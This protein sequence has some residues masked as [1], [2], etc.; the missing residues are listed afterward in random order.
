MAPFSAEQYL[1]SVPLNDSVSMFIHLCGTPVQFMDMNKC[2]IYQHRLH[3]CHCCYCMHITIADSLCTASGCRHVLGLRSI[4]IQRTPQSAHAHMSVYLDPC[5]N[6]YNLYIWCAV[7]KNSRAGARPASIFEIYFVYV[8]YEK[9][10]WCAL[11]V[12]GNYNGIVHL[13]LNCY[14]GYITRTNI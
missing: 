3:V 13:I 2:I 9:V 7:G 6:T 8:A 11:G 12:T 10:D 14:S 4:F 5:C 1:C